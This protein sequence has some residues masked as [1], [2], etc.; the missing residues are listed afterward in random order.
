MKIL[1]KIAAVLIMSVATTWVVADDTD[2]PAP[3]NSVALQLSAEK[4]ATTKTARVIVNVNAVLKSEALD[5]FR[6]QLLKNLAKLADDGAWHIT[7]FYRFQDQS[8]LERLQV[9]AEARLPDSALSNLRDGAKTI[10]KPGEQYTISD[11]QFTPSLEEVEQVKKDVRAQ[12]YADADADC[13]KNLL[14]GKDERV[15]HAFQHL[16]GDQYGFVS[17]IHLG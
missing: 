7:Q 13:D 11:I 4:W 9:T 14:F 15:L 1:S 2:K 8:G 3:I 6:T 17:V 10:S 16:G 12:I 5:S